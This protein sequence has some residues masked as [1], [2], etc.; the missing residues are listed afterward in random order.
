MS[1]L[2]DDDY[3]ATQHLLLLDDNDIDDTNTDDINIDEL[4]SDSLLMDD[5]LSHRDH[6]DG[7]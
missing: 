2:R 6:G 7:L 3:T 4:L 5:D 1:R